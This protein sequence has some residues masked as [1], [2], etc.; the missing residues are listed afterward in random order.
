MM[1]T[2]TRGTPNQPAL[3]F[4]APVWAFALR[5][6]QGPVWLSGTGGVRGTRHG[7]AECLNHATPWY[8]TDQARP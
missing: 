4:R 7:L 1:S 6:M 8:R 3:R 5:I 2:G